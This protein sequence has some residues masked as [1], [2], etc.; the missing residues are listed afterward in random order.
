MTKTH[1]SYAE[2]ES[3]KLVEA[4]VAEI[5]HAL[6]SLGLKKH[7]GLFDGYRF[8]SSKH[9]HRAADAFAF[10]RRPTRRWLEVSDATRDRDGIPTRSR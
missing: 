7:K 3:L 5:T 1:S 9:L 10:L 4:I 8:W 2:E 6:D